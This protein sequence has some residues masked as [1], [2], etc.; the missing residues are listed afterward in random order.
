MVYILQGRQNIYL[1][2]LRWRYEAALFKANTASV[3]EERAQ[4]MSPK[5]R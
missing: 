4:V 1:P 5:V 3:E 2:L